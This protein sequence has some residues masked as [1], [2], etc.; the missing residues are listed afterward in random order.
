MNATRSTATIVGV[1]YII[2]TVAGVLSVT[3]AGPVLE[4]SDYLA[5]IGANESPVT[6]GAL[7]ILIMGLALAMVPVV[8]FPIL[9]KQNEALALGYVV[10][11]GGLETF[12][13]IAV[14]ISWLLLVPVGQA[15]V[16]A[17]GPG[18]FQFAGSGESAARRSADRFCYYSD[19]LP[20]GCS[21]V[22]LPVV[23]SRTDPSMDLRLGSDCGN[24]LFS[25]R[26]DSDA[27]PR[28]AFLGNRDRTENS[29]RGARNGH[30]SVADRKGV[31]SLCGRFR[32]CPS[33]AVASAS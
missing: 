23:P 3:I 2:G 6:L 9:K 12:T 18:R 4:A 25:F 30:G 28:G 10:F 1:L 17:G 5:Q 11:R 19:R 14:V 21:D 13:Y 22:L 20:T 27:W 29:I 7:L 32:V 16:Q 8:M 26:R 15:Y 33:P 31:Q 24:P